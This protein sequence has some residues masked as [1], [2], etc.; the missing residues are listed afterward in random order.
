MQSRLNE[1]L[2]A[3]FTGWASAPLMSIMQMQCYGLHVLQDVQLLNQRELF[4][5]ALEGSQAF[6]LL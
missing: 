3:Y 2:G 6:L 5:D 4:V 1:P